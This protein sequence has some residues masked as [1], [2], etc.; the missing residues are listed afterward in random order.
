[1]HE[2]TTISLASKPREG[3]EGAILAGGK[4]RRMGKDKLLLPFG[5]TTVLGTVRRA[6]EP[7]V[8]RLRIVGREPSAAFAPLPSQPDLYPRLGPLSGIHAALATAEFDRVLIVACDLPF[9]TTEFL[10]GLVERLSP[11]LDAVIP[12]PGGEPLAVCAIYRTR[13]LETLTARLKRPDLAAREFARSLK[14][15]FLDDSDLR[16]LDPSG[17]ALLNLNTPRDY[18][19]ALAALEERK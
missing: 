8:Q 9:V 11:E 3:L 15:R 1:L 13:C 7:L 10:R 14:A 4:S 5:S 6:I 17:R 2:Y 19:R 12:C 18:R 16:T